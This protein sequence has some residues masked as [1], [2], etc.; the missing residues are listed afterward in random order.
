MKAI[1]V[2]YDQPTRKLFSLYAQVRNIREDKLSENDISLVYKNLAENYPDEWLLRLEILE[3]IREKSSVTELKSDIL[4]DLEKFK[5][6]STDQK[7]LIESS[8]KL[9]LENESGNVV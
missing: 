4:D 7:Q 5:N 3:Q 2:E 1:K 8:L 9:L 6:K